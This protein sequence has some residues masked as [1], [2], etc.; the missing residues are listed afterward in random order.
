MREEVKFGRIVRS[1]AMS[2]S[3]NQS[4]ISFSI[5]SKT[6]FGAPTDVLQINSINPKTNK[7]TSHLEIQI[8]LEYIDDVIKA[9]TKIKNDYETM[10]NI[11]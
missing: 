6:R 11:I 9:L 10:A 8:P 4:G 3:P 7:E 5:P 2:K 1:H